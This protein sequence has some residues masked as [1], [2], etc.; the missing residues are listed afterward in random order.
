M[1]SADH[2]IDFITHKYAMT[3]SLENTVKVQSFHFQLCFKVAR[4]MFSIEA[5]RAENGEWKVLLKAGRQVSPIVCCVTLD[6]AP[7]SCYFPH[8]CQMIESSQ[9]SC[10]MHEMTIPAKTLCIKYEIVRRQ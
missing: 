6:K 3:Y 5:A 9:Q 1:V 7:L 2:Q 4:G 8:T 10:Y